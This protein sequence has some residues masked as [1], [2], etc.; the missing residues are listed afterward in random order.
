MWAEGE[1]AGARR[2]EGFA[3]PVVHLIFSLT[4]RIHFADHNIGA[5]GPHASGGGFMGSVASG[6]GT[7]NLLVI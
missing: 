4:C 3:F 6:L 5:L 1:W 2:D 7:V